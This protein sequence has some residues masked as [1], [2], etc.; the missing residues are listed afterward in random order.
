MHELGRLREEAF[1]SIGEG[2]GK[3]LD[4]DAF[5]PYY[6]HLILWDNKKQQV[7]GATSIHQQEP[8]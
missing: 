4:T 6:K 2:T 8:V 5:D 3:R 1:R 7:A